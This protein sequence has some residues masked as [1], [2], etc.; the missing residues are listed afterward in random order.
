VRLP[1]PGIQ[2]LCAAGGTGIERLQ[3]IEPRLQNWRSRTAV[4]TG[5]NTHPE[6]ARRVTALLHRRPAVRLLKRKTFRGT[7]SAGRCGG[8]K[9]SAEDSCGKPYEDRQ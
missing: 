4:G 5:M 2:R 8:G 6:F 9:R 7:G 3:S 1:W